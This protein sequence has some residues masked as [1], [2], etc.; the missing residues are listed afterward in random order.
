MLTLGP[1]PVPLLDGRAPEVN[2]MAEEEME[3]RT[4]GK[5]EKDNSRPSDPTRQNGR[6]H[7]LI[8]TKI[9]LSIYS[10]YFSGSPLSVV[11]GENGSTVER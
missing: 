10:K 2:W 4:H 1:A 5:V 7:P 8:L 9:R 3:E 11:E 6:K